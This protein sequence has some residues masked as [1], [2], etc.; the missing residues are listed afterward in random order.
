[1]LVILYPFGHLR[2]ALHAQSGH[3]LSCEL[4]AL[5][6]SKTLALTSAKAEK[7]YYVKELDLDRRHYPLL[8][9]P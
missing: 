9:T 6:W 1:M 3:C 8:R 5:G 2:V 7:S 4:R